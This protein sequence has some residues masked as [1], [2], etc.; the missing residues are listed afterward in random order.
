M[1][2]LSNSIIHTNIVNTPT[3]EDQ[4]QIDSHGGTEL[5]ITSN[6]KNTDQSQDKN[7]KQGI[8]SYEVHKNYLKLISGTTLDKFQSISSNDED[9]SDDP[10]YVDQ[11][12]SSNASGEYASLESEETTS[13]EHA[14]NLTEFFSPHALV[15]VVVSSTFD[16]A[17]ESVHLSPRGKG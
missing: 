4:A 1:N 3:R 11:E 10:N 2:A 16:N 13:D 9:R 5:A 17:I 6:K 7:R 12:E 14:K 8:E 15:D